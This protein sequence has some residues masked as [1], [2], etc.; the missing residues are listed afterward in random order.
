M[1][2]PGPAHDEE[3]SL[4]LPAEPDS[5]AAAR[6]LVR[7][8]AT[9]HDVPGHVRDALLLCVSEAATNVVEHA[10]LHQAPGGFRVAVTLAPGAVVVRVI[11][12]GRGMRPAHRQPG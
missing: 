7:E 10:Y 6:E 1:S 5:V 3:A 11:D 4:R 2:E 9:T 12:H 8:F